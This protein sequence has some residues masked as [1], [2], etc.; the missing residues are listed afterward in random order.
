MAYFDALYVLTEVGSPNECFYHVV[1]IEAEDKEKAEQVAKRKRTFR[2][3]SRGVKFYSARFWCVESSGTLDHFIGKN[4]G[5]FIQ[6][7]WGRHGK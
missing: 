1:T 7:A 3:Q 4:V 5:D 2:F 6:I